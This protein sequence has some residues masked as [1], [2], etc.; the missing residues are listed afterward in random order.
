MTR[1]ARLFDRSGAP[2]D[3]PFRTLGLAPG[4]SP[5]DL[6]DAYRRG[7]LAHPPERDP[8]GFRRV[9]EAYRRLSHD[10]KV[11]ERH[12]GVLEIGSPSDYGL[13]QREC[14]DSSPRPAAETILGELLLYAVAE[15]LRRSSLAG[16]RSAP[17]GADSCL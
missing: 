8:D 15:A 10:S 5:D 11:E 17:F 9:S 4:A 6:R 2:I 13:L 3:D 14:S 1:L 16:T 7:V 12:L